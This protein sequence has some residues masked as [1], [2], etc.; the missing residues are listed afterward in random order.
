MISIDNRKSIYYN[1]GVS[2]RVLF[3]GK[4]LPQLFCRSAEKSVRS[5]GGRRAERLAPAV[6]AVMMWKR[7]GSVLRDSFV[8]RRSSGVPHAA[9]MRCQR[10]ASASNVQ[11]CQ[12]VS[13]VFGR[14]ASYDAV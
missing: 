2:T 5:N 3:L 6:H 4:R 8:G 7:T 13:A 10:E 14:N 12:I 11:S 9:K 1:R